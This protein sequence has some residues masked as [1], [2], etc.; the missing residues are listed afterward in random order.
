[1]HA[2]DT[3]ILS[4]AVVAVI[5]GGL[6][7]VPA[8]L[9]AQ[10]QDGLNETIH[11]SASVNWKVYRDGVL[12]HDYTNHNLLTNEGK[13]FIEAELG[14]SGTTDEVQYVAMSNDGTAPAAGDTTCPS[15]ITT[16]GLERALG[17]YTST[18]TGV[19][20]ISKTFTA[21]GAQSAQKSCLL[22]DATAGEPDTLFAESLMTSVSLQTNDQVT[23]TWTITVS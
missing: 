17:A 9:Q 21:T 1:M 18:G 15:E 8:L 16:N 13:E 5:L 3:A 22:T 19:W 6:L 14:N 23:V 2:K 10:Q 20:T 4:I 11:Y 7:V 12:I